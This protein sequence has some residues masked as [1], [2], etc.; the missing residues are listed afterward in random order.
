MLH[1]TVMR[2]NIQIQFWNPFAPLL[3]PS[4]SAVRL[5]GDVRPTV[6]R[7]SRAIATPS[8]TEPRS[9]RSLTEF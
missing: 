5:F 8:A 9:V 3:A 7:L 1:S 4:A 6:L 2:P